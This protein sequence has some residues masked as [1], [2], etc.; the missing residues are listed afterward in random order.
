MQRSPNRICDRIPITKHVV[1]PK[2]RD[3]KPF[4]LKPCSTIRII[5]A[6]ER[7]LSAVEFDNES[8]FETNKVDDK[9]P[10]RNLAA[11]FKLTEAPTAKTLPDEAFC[12]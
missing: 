11:K 3:A 5:L 10:Q 4:L 9:S 12:F 2:A 6:I 7:V 1:I 8:M